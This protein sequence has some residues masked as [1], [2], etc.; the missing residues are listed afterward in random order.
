MSAFMK[1]LPC[2]I[3]LPAQKPRLAR[4]RCLEPTP[5]FHNLTPTLPVYGRYQYESPLKGSPLPQAMHSSHNSRS[6]LSQHRQGY[7]SALILKCS[8]YKRHEVP[9]KAFYT[10]YL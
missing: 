4:R 10:P 9:A 5:T 7:R 8:S 6:I 2:L 1:T 3:A